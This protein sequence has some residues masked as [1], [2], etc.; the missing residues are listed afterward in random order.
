[1]ACTKWMPQSRDF[2]LT[3]EALH[4]CIC[5]GDY[6]RLRTLLET[7][8]P[9]ALNH[10]A[11]HWGSALHVAIRYDSAEAIN[12]LLSAG[13]DPVTHREY[14]GM[15]FDPPSPM[16]LAI[17]LGRLRIVKRFWEHVPAA[18]YAN[19]G[20]MAY[21]SCI[22][23][24]ARCGQVESL[25]FFLDAWNG[26]SAGALREALRLAAKG[27]D[28]FCVE[29]LLAKT[30]F[31]VDVLNEALQTTIL[32][33]SYEDEEKVSREL[34]T[35][36]EGLSQERIMRVLMEK[37][38][39]PDGLSK[40]PEPLLTEAA[41]YA[42]RATALRVLLEAGANPNAARADGNTALHLLAVPV[43]RKKNALRGRKHHEQGI[44]LLLRHGAS[45]YTKA[46]RGGELPLHRAAFGSTLCLFQ[47]YVGALTTDDQHGPALLQLANGYGETLLH[48][49]AAGGKAD[50]LEY[51]LSL[52]SGAAHVDDQ[53][54]NGWT[55]LMCA[56]VPQMSAG[57]GASESIRAARVLL[58]HGADLRTVTAE[59]WTPLHALALHTDRDTDS[60]TAAHAM[61]TEL[62][63]AGAD[64]D[65]RAAL[66]GR[67]A[68][69]WG[70]EA[71]L[72]LE[73]AAALTPPWLKTGM[74]PLM[75]A[76]D[77]GAFGVSRAL[78][79]W[80]GVDMA[81]TDDAGRDVLRI[82]WESRHLCDNVSYLFPR[83]SICE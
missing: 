11:D 10:L 38:A 76:A 40:R 27:L 83:N 77:R 24:A 55:P 66:P 34:C 69:A 26:W 52:E 39:D 4:A 71:R 68:V 78:M 22:S 14:R 80:N 46:A 33:N 19:G 18:T 51:L 65:A 81:A 9:E 82:A 59:G 16:M 49:A 60:G 6:T 31:P 70:H 58:T 17:G 1:M 36:A 45:V 12:L 13:A 75:W 64:A 30:E 35:A 73:E 72:A 57:K 48:W 50:I 63:A 25:A 8:S 74:T 79:E 7:T 3:Q 32:D 47:L 37:G 44:R 41:R 2:S 28:L 15:A 23:H 29:L 67:R 20:K 56:L 53:T 62:L 61:T 43:Q 54:D 21:W 5:E 42:E